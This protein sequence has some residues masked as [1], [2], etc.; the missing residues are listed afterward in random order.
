MKKLFYFI[1]IINITCFTILNFFDY[2]NNIIDTIENNK[3]NIEVKKPKNL[4]NEEYVN[5][6][7]RDFNKINEDIMY[8]R[9][10]NSTKKSHYKYYVT[11]NTYNFLNLDIKNENTILSTANNLGQGKKI[12]GSSF[13]NNTSIYNFKEIKKFNLDVCQFYV[14][15]DISHAIIKNLTNMGY[16]LDE[17]HYENLDRPFVS[18][19]TMALPFFLLAIS[20]IFYTIS[21]R[22][23][24]LCKRLMGYSNLNIILED[25]IDNSKNIILIGLIIEILNL[26]IVNFIYSNS[27][28]NYFNFTYK[29]LG[30]ILLCTILILIFVNLVNLLRIEVN[31]LKG[32][33]ENIDIYIITL[34]TKVIFCLLLIISLTSISKSIISMYSLNKINL[35]ISKKLKTYVTLPINDSNNSINDFNQLEYNKQFDKFYDETVNKFDGILI[36]TRDYKRMYQTGKLQRQLNDRIIINE[37]YLKINKIHDIK[38]NLINKERFIKGHLNILIPETISENKIKELYSKMEE[39]NINNI[40]IIKYLN[41]ERIYS[42]SPYSGPNNKGLIDNPIIVIYDKNIFKNQMLNYVSGEYYL[43]KTKTDNPYDEIKPNLIK[44]KLD[45]VIPE[46]H[47]IS[48]VF[49][50]FISYIKVHLINDLIKFFVYIVGTFIMLIYSSKIYFSSHSEEISCKRLSGY[51]F[52]EVYRTPLIIQVVQIVLFLGLQK[53]LRMNFYI[54]LIVSLL[55]LFIFSMYSIRYQTKGILNVLKGEK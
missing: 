19:Q 26:T 3:V 14:K 52:I 12:I 47:Y 53:Y 38:G 49:D 15:K 39:I 21:K 10:D 27:F 45:G 41:G 6:L 35:D 48:N 5:K 34:G 36:D 51:S 13:F 32:K 24:I 18:I 23:E 30:V 16:S 28:W 55:E 17:V 4:T 37:N 29:K 31:Y 43:L 54:I 22:K 8:K 42:F 25:C 33:N 1:F 44:Y 50:T 11:N 2:S 7:V 40:N 46:V 20:M 9:V